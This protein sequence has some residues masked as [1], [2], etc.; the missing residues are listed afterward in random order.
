M[1]EDVGEDAKSVKPLDYALRYARRGWSLFPIRALLKDRPLIKWS[2]F[3]SANAI[4]I[5]RWWSTWPAANVGLDCGRSRVCVLDVDIKND[6]DGRPALDMLEL[7]YGALP[8]TRMQRTQT[9][10]LQYLFRGM[11]PNTVNILG[12]GL[13]TRG[14]GGMVLLPPSRTANGRY[15]WLNNLP[16]ADVPAW[17]GERLGNHVHQHVDQEPVADLDQPAEIEWY[18]EWL[19]DEA[20]RSIMGAGGGDVLVKLIVPVGKDRGL[21]RDTV[22]DILAES[23]G[24]ND[25]KCEPAWD[26]SDDAVNGLYKKVDNGFDYCRANAPGSATAQADFADDP[27]TDAEMAEIAAFAAGFDDYRDRRD[28]ETDDDASLRLWAVRS[29]K[30]NAKRNA[31]RRKNTRQQ[32]KDARDKLLKIGAVEIEGEIAKALTPEAEPVLV[33][34]VYAG[35]AVPDAATEFGDDE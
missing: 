24:Y 26:H 28:G 33:A 4:S 2:L 21:T 17:I 6:K 14:P 22:K 30:V 25:T 15:R 3:A 11:L 27:V 20:P 18:R 7:E 34:G 8:P 1:S 5:N 29:R 16:L 13:D 32:F 23:G 9:G 31:K 19:R 35:D 10:G 12:R